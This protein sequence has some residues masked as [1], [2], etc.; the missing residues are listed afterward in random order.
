[1]ADL[2]K[3]KHLLLLC[4]AWLC[5]MPLRAQ[6]DFVPMG[7]RSSAMGGASV[8]LTD[9]ESALHNPAA[10]ALQKQTSLC[11]AYSQPMNISEIATAY[12]GIILPSSTGVWAAN[13]LHYGNSN[14]HEQQA[15]MAYALRV[16]ETMHFGVAFL[17]LNAATAD[18]YYAPQHLQTFTASLL[19]A[20]SDNLCIGARIYNPTAVVL[21]GETAL[22]TP[23]IFNLGISHLLTDELLATAEIEKNFY[24][25]ASLRMG[26]E[27]TFLDICHARIGLATNP[28]IYTFGFGI[29]HEH[30]AIDL[31]TQVHHS[32]GWLPLLSMHYLF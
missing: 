11:L 27:Y 14:Y 21:R 29:S 32:L 9:A 30:L 19:Y 4:V 16:T 10:L 3:N 6:F 17:Y 20:P 24:H 5:T 26:L 18:P 25:H 22:H 1:M 15:S 8:A 28:I 7:G 12:A 2:I 13:Y 31:A 23:T